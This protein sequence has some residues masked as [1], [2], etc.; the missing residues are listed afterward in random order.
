MNEHLQTLPVSVA[1]PRFLVEH[2]PSFA[3]EQQQQERLVSRPRESRNWNS[4]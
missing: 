3:R 4:T 1:R 2:F